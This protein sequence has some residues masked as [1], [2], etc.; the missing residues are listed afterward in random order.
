MENHN[1]DVALS[2]KEIDH[3]HQFTN[4]YEDLFNKRA[5]LYKEYELKGKK[6]QLSVVQ[7]LCQPRHGLAGE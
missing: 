3:L 4:S 6:D 5:K 1:N 7:Q 2:E